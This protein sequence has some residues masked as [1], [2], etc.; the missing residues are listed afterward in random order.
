VHIVELKVVEAVVE[1]Q[2]RLGYRK[3][4]MSECGNNLFCEIRFFANRLLNE[5]GL[6]T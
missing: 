6:M 1:K 4:F 3:K 5:E 2:R